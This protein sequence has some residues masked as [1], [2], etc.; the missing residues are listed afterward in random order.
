MSKKYIQEILQLYAVTDRHW[1]GTQTLAQQVE[2][3]LKGGVTCVQLREKNLDKKLFLQEA[4]EIKKIC[5][6]YHVP[7]LINDDIAIALQS[8]ADGVHV[9]QNDMPVEEV[10]KILGRNKIIGVTVKTVEQ[11]IYAQNNE[12]DYLGVGAVFSTST[13]TDAI[14]IEKETIKA[15]CKSVKIPIVAI[16]GIT[17][18]NILQLTEFDIQGVALVSAIFSS[19]DI[20]KTCRKLKILSKQ[21]IN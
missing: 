5:N 14:K 21:I 11:A 18:E 3:A 8:N 20:E 6:Y 9:G 17:Q 12:A 15:I 4:L 13:K 7:L 10:R 2:S 16:G 19:Q 1:L